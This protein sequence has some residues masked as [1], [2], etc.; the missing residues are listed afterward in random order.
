MTTIEAIAIVSKATCPEDIFGTLTEMTDN[1][2]AFAK[3]LHPDVTLGNKE[4]AEAFKKVA[5][6]HD[7]AEKR[8]ADGTYGQRKPIEKPLIIRTKATVYEVRG[9]RF[10]GDL[11]QIYEAIADTGETVLLKIP[12]DPRNNDL[13]ES[14]A[15][16][17]KTI[18]KHCESHRIKIGQHCGQVIE[19]F[20]LQQGKIK[21]RVNVVSDRVGFVTLADVIAAY[22]NGIHLADAAWMFNRLIAA[23][24]AA[25]QSGIVHGAVTPDH[26]LI[27]PSTHNGILID[28][29]YSAQAGQRIRAV[30]P[31]W[32]TMY[33]PEIADK[34]V[35]TFGFDLYMATDILTSLVGGIAQIH[36]HRRLVG[37]IRACHLGKGAR[38]QDAYEVFNDFKELLQ[39]AFGKPKFREFKMPG[40][41]TNKTGD[42]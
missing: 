11:C 41:T 26:I 1:F 29:C 13:L 23:L 25:H 40:E 9:V 2:R 4:S 37:L 20:E 18:Q 16:N 14:E 39:D 5:S 19:S 6:Y 32:K 36:Q 15:R 8:I 35:A 38:I 28:W 31:K 17:A 22:P 42:K 33:P 3:L 27:E 10:I 21:K 34:P 12:R 7:A 30:A 24:A